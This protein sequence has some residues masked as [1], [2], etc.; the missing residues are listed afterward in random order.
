MGIGTT[1]RTERVSF[2]GLASIKSA[3]ERARSAFR[4]DQKEFVGAMK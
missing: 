3:D 2:L 4:G 1:S